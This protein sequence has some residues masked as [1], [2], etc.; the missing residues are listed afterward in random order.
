MINFNQLFV[1]QYLQVIS[2][3]SIYKIKILQKFITSKLHSINLHLISKTINPLNKQQSKNGKKPNK[4]KKNKIKTTNKKNVHTFS[5]IN[6]TLSI[7][8]L[9]T[10]SSN[11]SIKNSN[12]IS[13][14]KI[15][16]LMSSSLSQP[17]SYNSIKPLDNSHI[18][19]IPY[20]VTG[21]LIYKL[22][23]L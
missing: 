2:Y 12:N 1:N 3:N 21:S 13:H 6:K 16:K 10:Y 7:I 18:P 9:G 23:H 11:I 20:F 8:N 22:T 14:N 5:S 19:V 17:F 4:S 15:A